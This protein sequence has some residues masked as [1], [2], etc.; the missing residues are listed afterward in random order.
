MTTLRVSGFTLARSCSR[1]TEVQLCECR[2][3]QSST[4]GQSPLLSCAAPVP[5]VV[6][7]TPSSCCKNFKVG[8][9]QDG[10]VVEHQIEIKR[11]GKLSSH[12]L[13]HNWKSQPQHIIKEG[14]LY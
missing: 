10:Q 7:I 8:R 4:V 3:Y 1:L 12:A 14:K 5:V 11:A 2:E 6:L 13:Q 9:D